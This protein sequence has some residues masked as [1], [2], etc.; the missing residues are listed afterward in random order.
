MKLSRGDD[1]ELLLTITDPDDNT[2]VDLTGCTV[3]F[4]VK[5]VGDS[6]DDDT[7]AL[8][9][10]TQNVHTDPTNG[11]TSIQL[12]NADTNITAWTYV[13]DFQVKDTNNQIIS[14]ELWKLVVENDATRRTS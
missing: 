3:F 1:I 6:S 2:A 13:Y 11:K 14:T 10:K 4:T 7:T 5:K 9:A 12:T 8:I